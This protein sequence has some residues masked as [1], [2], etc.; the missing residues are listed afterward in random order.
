VKSAAPWSQARSSTC[1][2]RRMPTSFKASKERTE[3]TAG[4][5]VVPA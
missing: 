4:I 3:L 5:T 1:E 2:T